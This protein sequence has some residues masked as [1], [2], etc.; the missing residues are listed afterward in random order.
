[1]EFL[2]FSHGIR[3]QSGAHDALDA[4]AVAIQTCKVNWILDANIRAFFDRIERDWLR[5]FLEHRIG[6]RRVICLI[7]KW[8]NAGVMESGKW[9][10]ELRG[11]PQGAV[12][13]PIL[14]NIHLHYV[15]DFVVSQ[16][17]SKRAGHRGSDHRKI[18]R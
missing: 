14:A 13:S 10:D 9:Q 17:M 18:C 15:L 2:G 16:Q 5:R 8:L 3:P 1:M 6:D 11:T 4:L 7:I 12:I